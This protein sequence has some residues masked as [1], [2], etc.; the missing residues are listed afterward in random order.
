MHSQFIKAYNLSIHSTYY[1]VKTILYTTHVRRQCTICCIV[2]CIRIVVTTGVSRGNRKSMDFPGYFIT[3][4]AEVRQKP[5]MQP[6]FIRGF[7][8]KTHFFTVFCT[9]ISGLLKQIF[10]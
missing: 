9:R 8:K 5:S 4:F 1:S 6:S 2:Q 3:C 7:H 10:H